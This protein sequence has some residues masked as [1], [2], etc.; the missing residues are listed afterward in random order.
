[1]V[2]ALH[3]G[4]VRSEAAAPDTMKTLFFLRRDLADRQR[5]AGVRHVD[6]HVDLIDVEPLVGDLVPM[7]G[8]F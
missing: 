6:D 5:D 2:L 4:P 7:S 3:F 8:L 1:M